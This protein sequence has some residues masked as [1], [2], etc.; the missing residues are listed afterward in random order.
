MKTNKLI[1][2]SKRKK[3]TRKK[4]NIRLGK[5]N[6]H[7]NE[8]SQPL[9]VSKLIQWATA[10]KL[11]KYETKTKVKIKRAQ[12]KKKCTC[13]NVIQQPEKRDSQLKRLQ[14][15]QKKK[16]SQANKYIFVK[17]KHKGR[18]YR[19]VNVLKYTPTARIRTTRNI[20][21]D[22]HPIFWWW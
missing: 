4:W 5:R 14:E 22:I 15:D 1:K 16:P 11:R 20:T 7:T 21:V 19:I 12:K 17:L 10:N 13:D 8:W 18:F 9:N 2:K 3:T 6:T